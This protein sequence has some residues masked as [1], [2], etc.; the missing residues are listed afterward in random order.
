MRKKGEELSLDSA[1]A[2][3]IQGTTKGVAGP[4]LVQY[5]GTINN[6]KRAEVGK[7]TWSAS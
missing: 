5:I 6:P 3:P 1:R 7:K 2:A 4:A